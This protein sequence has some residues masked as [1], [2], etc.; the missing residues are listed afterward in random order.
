MSTSQISETMVAP[1]VVRRSDRGLCVAGH[2]ITLYLIEDYLRAGWP[3]HLLRHSLRLSD[4][5]MTEVLDYLAANRSE[6]D[7]EYERVA[8]EA[9]E[10]EKYW[11]EQRR[12]R[13]KVTR[14]KFTPEQAAAWA[15][16]NALRRQGKA[17]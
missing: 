15:R 7:R 16:L 3:P 6:F 13:L 2:R 17:A 9:T 11:R 5:E 14:R 12:K 4:Q 1:G 10:R 8:R